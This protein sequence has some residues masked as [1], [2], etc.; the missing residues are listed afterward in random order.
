MGYRTIS[1]GVD[2]EVDVDYDRIL[3]KT[4]S[5]GAFALEVDSGEGG[6]CSVKWSWSRA[7]ELF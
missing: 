5:K 1:P 7:I 4:E 6:M 2:V 3:F